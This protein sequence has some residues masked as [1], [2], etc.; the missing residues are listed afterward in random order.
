MGEA[1][2]LTNIKPDSRSLKVVEL[3]PKPFG[4]KMLICQVKKLLKPNLPRELTP[5][6]GMKRL[7]KSSR[8]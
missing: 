4:I 1:F 5:R 3:D 7:L 8:N 2:V 6:C